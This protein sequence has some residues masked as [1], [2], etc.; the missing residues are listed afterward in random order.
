MRKSWLPGSRLASTYKTSPPASV[1]ASPVEGDV[2]GTG[3]Q[4]YQGESAGGLVDV[5]VALG[6][7]IVEAAVAGTVVE[8]VDA[9]VEANDVVAGVGV[10]VDEC[11]T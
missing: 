7:G 1:Q 4:S 5:E 6:V 2:A 11:G 10:G 3:A 8:G 9:G